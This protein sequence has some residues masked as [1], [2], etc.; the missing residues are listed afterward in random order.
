M[1]PAEWMEIGALDF[2]SSRTLEVISPT[3]W[4]HIQILS[5]KKVLLYEKYWSYQVMILH[6]PSLP[7]FRLMTSSTIGEMWTKLIANLLGDSF[8]NDISS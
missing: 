2:G 1:H 3:V 6:M 7:S 8:F 4:D 5:K